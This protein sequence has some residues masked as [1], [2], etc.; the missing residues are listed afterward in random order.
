[1]IKKIGLLEIEF[2]DFDPDYSPTNEVNIKAAE[3]RGLRFERRTMHYVDDD[4]CLIL[5]EY[6]QPLG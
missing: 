6:G 1:M 2:I 4:G 3:Q 5:D